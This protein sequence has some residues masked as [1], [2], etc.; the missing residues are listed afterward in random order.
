[1]HVKVLNW[2]RK[3][4]RDEATYETSF[5][6]LSDA[7]LSTSLHALNDVDDVKHE[8]QDQ[9]SHSRAVHSGF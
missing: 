9:E 3:T 4:H 1:M 5:R 2:A 7:I 6:Q 8:A